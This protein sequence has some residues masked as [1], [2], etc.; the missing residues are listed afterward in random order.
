MHKHPSYNQR[1]YNFHA[2]DSLLNNF[3]NYVTSPLNE[4]KNY[5]HARQIPLF[6]KQLCFTRNLKATRRRYTH[7]NPWNQSV[8]SARRTWKPSR[9]ANTRGSW[10]VLVKIILINSHARRSSAINLAATS[11]LTVHARRTQGVSVSKRVEQSSNNTNIAGLCTQSIS[12]GQS[13]PRVIRVQRA[14]FIHRTHAKGVSFY[15]Y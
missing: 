8:D 6:Y 15:Y 5:L 7:R 12:R 11:S 10:L 2:L 1:F 3:S 9:M 13:L 14:S 4:S